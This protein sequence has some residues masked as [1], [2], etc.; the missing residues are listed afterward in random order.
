MKVPIEIKKKHCIGKSFI[1]L[2]HVMNSFLHAIQ[3]KKSQNI[4]G[5]LGERK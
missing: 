4:V 1:C 5:Y 2:Y 3:Q